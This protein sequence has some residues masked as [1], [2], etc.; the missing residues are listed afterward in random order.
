MKNCMSWHIV[1]F[2]VFRWCVGVTGIPC[3]WSIVTEAIGGGNGLVWKIWC[4]FS[5]THSH[6]FFF[7]TF[8]I[9]RR[10]ESV[11]PATFHRSA[12]MTHNQNTLH[13]YSFVYLHSFILYAVQVNDVNCFSLTL[14]WAHIGWEILRKPTYR[15]NV[16]VFFFREA[17]Y[18]WMCF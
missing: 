5:C 3:Q 12:P 18:A 1:F 6:L 14:W 10:N 13:C 11:A 2:F 8:D 9:F 15:I 17:L 16:S 7:G 4:L